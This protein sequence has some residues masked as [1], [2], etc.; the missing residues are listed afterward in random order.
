MYW[1]KNNSNNNVIL[2]FYQEEFILCGKLELDYDN[3]E[4]IDM[5]HETSY[6]IM[7]NNL[8]YIKALDYIFIVKEFSKLINRLSNKNNEKLFFYNLFIKPMLKPVSSYFYELNS[9]HY[10]N[11]EKMLEDLR[12]NMFDI[13][14]N[15][16]RHS[17]ILSEKKLSEYYKYYEIDFD[18]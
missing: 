14:E 2:D 12:N 11:D 7:L 4:F 5:I 8:S 17:N 3:A 9:P 16:I 1:Y 13:I 15:L 18:Y 6:Y 10:T